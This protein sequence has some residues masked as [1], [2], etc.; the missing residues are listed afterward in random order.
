MTY[1]RDPDTVTL[2]MTPAEYSQLLLILGYAT[3]SASKANDKEMA[4]SVLA[5]A[6]ALNATNPDFRQYAI[7][8]EP[9]N[10]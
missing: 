10:G 3:G 8:E 9:A 7:P 1:T 5:F 2:E 4:Y 6:N